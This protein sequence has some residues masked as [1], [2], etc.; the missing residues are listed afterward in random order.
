MFE[1]Y[2]PRFPLCFFP[3]ISQ[4]KSRYVEV[5]GHT[6]L[7]A[8]NYSLESGESSVWGQEVDKTIPPPRKPMTSYMIF[9]K[10]YREEHFP[11]PPEGKNSRKRKGGAAAAA[12]AAAEGGGEGDG[13]EGG[14]EGGEGAAAPKSKKRGPKTAGPSQAKEQMDALVAAWR[15]L[16]DESRA[17]YDKEAE[18]F[19]AA[20]EAEVAVWQE[21]V[22]A[23]QEARQKIV[24]ERRAIP[25]AGGASGAIG[26][27][28]E[29]VRSRR[30]ASTA[31]LAAGGGNPSGRAEN[32]HSVSWA[33]EVLAVLTPPPPGSTSASSDPEGAATATLPSSSSSSSSS[34][35]LENGGT[36]T[37]AEHDSN[38][39]S[40]E[41]D[42][43]TNGA[44]S[45]SSSSSSTS[46]SLVAVNTEE[47][48]KPPADE[49]FVEASGA[50]PA[51]A[52]TDGTAADSAD[53]EESANEPHTVGMTFVGIQQKLLSKNLERRWFELRA[54]LRSLLR[55]GEAR[56]TL[57]ECQKDDEAMVQKLEAQ[58]R[59][60]MFAMR[61]RGK[62]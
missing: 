46:T 2:F 51:A 53:G 15:A 14:G 8:N 22:L 39:T 50:D 27:G 13:G 59:I 61:K 37:S 23:Q 6:V 18:E 48:K 52:T 19:K 16:D 42:E 25:G 36:A 5:D 17:P 54:P 57:V 30:A 9:S 4:V 12:A 41:V 43:T 11:D 62:R 33:S 1:K 10:K 38:N 34:L 32:E 40:M 28:N 35:L 31:S 24:R 26:G 44:S 29:E 21:K 55:R 56:R 20:Y 7:K 3:R 49:F 47:V 45:S 58:V 60:A